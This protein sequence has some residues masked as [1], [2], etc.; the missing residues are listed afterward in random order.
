[1]RSWHRGWLTAHL[2][3]RRRGRLALLACVPVL[4]L[5]GWAAASPARAA[6][7]AAQRVSVPRVDHVFLIMEENNGLKDVVPN[8]AAPNL[9]YLARTFGLETSYFGVS[10]DSSESNY[11]GLL[12]GS[13]HGVTSDDA[14]WKNRIGAPSLISQLDRAGISWKAYLQGLPHPDYQ[15][16]CYPAR[17]NGAPDSDPLYV[18]KHDAI[19]NFTTSWNRRDWSRQVPI[20]EL[21][22]DLRTGDV[23]RFSYVVPDECHDMHGDPPYCLDS[24]NIRDPQNQH[25]VAQ[26]DAYLGHLVSEITH[27]PFWAQGNN[28]IVVTYDNGDN[29]AGC[30]DA[31]PGG[32]RVA[33]VV[34]TS[35]GPRRIQDA[36]PANHYSLLSTLQHIFGVGCLQYTCDTAHVHPLYS[37]FTDIGSAPIATRARPEQTWPTPTPSRPAEPRSMTS[38]T[39]SSGGWTVQ[40]TQRLGSNDNS[41]GAVAGSS[42]TDVWAVGDFLPSAKHSNQDATLSFAEHY[43]G[44]TW[45]VVRTPNAGP[46]FNSFYGLA[47]SGGRAWAVGERLNAQYQDRALVEYW[48]GAKW[49]I[50][51]VP[52]PGTVRDMLFGASALSPSDV[53]VV[54]DRE[55][56][57]GVFAALAE[58]WNGK[59]W[60]VVPTPDP[61]SAGNHLYAVD[62]VSPDDVW[63]AGQQLSGR[64]PDRGLIEHWN[65]H[66][67]SVMTSPRAASASVLFDAV[68]ATPGQAWVAGEADSPAGG[69]RPLI[70]HYAAGVWSIAHLPVSAGSDWT[71]LYG[72][73]RAGGSVWAAGTYV[74]PRTDSNNALVLRYSG[75]TWSV[76]NAPDP[77]SGSNIPGGVTAVGGQL[78]LAGVY[79]NG[80]SRL[81]LVEHR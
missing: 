78:W 19:Q 17:C 33:T 21:A 44:K 15:G 59:Q 38:S 56:G 18:S 57:N 64:A 79:D 65:G 24:G 26:G 61:G 62:A 74:D 34:V 45:T 70:E 29:A 22:A 4:G 60:S 20:G 25:L 36:Q 73:A 41:L 6:T 72:L 23:P 52:Q 49:G 28:A 42:P 53:W 3:H 1:M 9:D 48:N 75:G 46:N 51:R 69:G 30:C 40:R 35:H 55:G 39:A 77:G 47:A 32:G 16:I 37:L 67:W 43:N 11:V 80:G 81:P 71:N 12:G 27:A 76:D 50:A 68:T 54:G 66:R 5:T 58:H 14:Y 63:A 2:P 8:P 13:T 7:P 10:P 31:K